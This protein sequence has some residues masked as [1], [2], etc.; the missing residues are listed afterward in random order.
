METVP[1]SF[2]HRFVLPLNLCLSHFGLCTMASSMQF[3]VGP[4][5]YD[6]DTVITDGVVCYKCAEFSAT[7]WMGLYMHLRHHCLTEDECLLLPGSYLVQ[8][9]TRE[10]STAPTM[11]IT[12]GPP[13]YDGNTV[14]TEGVVCYK[15]QAFWTTSWM[16]LYM[17]LRHRCLTEDECLLL[18]GSYLVHEARREEREALAQTRVSEM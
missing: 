10:H 6:S 4:P 11:Q 15:C 13:P 7:T 1:S 5:P 8:E 12:A 18:P 9:A 2:K 14:I 16:R 17:H 3:T